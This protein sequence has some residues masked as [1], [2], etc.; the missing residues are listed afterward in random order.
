M[1]LVGVGSVL[2]YLHIRKTKRDK[3]EDL[4]DRFQNSDYGLDEIPA[5]RKPRAD[6]DDKSTGGS[7]SPSGYGRRSRDPLQAGTEPKYNS[8][9]GQLNGHL[10]P[11]DDGSSN[12]SNPAWP[13][14]EGSQPSPLGKGAG[15]LKG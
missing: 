3:R 15:D 1:L 7:P 12:G 6:D 14:R 13:K 4:E 10:I 8:R 5:G 2:L 9:S 11:F